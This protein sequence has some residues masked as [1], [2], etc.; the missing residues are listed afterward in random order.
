MRGTAERRGGKV[1]SF[2]RASRNDHACSQGLP[3]GHEAAGTTTHTHTHTQA[4][5]HMHNHITLTR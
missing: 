1:L 3:H 4:H 2:P 5:N